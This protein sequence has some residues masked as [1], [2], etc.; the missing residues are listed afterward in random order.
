MADTEKELLASKEKIMQLQ[1]E[2][3]ELFVSF[4]FLSDESTAC[5]SLLDI[6]KEFFK[7]Y[8]KIIS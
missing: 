8:L 3:S 6:C 5:A 1:N 4:I 2:V 7:I